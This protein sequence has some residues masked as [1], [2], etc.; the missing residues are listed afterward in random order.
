MSIL[1]RIAAFGPKE[2][3]LAEAK[4]RNLPQEMIDLAIKRHRP[5]KPKVVS[6]RKKLA[7]EQIPMWQILKSLGFAT[8]K[9]YLLS[10]LWKQ[11][12]SGILGQ[13]INCRMCNNS[14]AQAVHHIFYSP[15]NM[16]GTNTD[17]LIPICNSCHY[18]CEF[19]RRG[20]K[21]K[22]NRARQSSLARL[23]KG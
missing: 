20:K 4:K 19:D 14:P 18:K 16:N 5:K 23:K 17:G 1:N 22:H 7:V 10:D 9:E 3:L 12:R 2:F 13:G 6:M 15:E 21:R 11:I 8:Y